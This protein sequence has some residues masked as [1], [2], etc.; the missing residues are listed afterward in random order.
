MEDHEETIPRIYFKE[1]VRE[2]LIKKAGIHLYDSDLDDILPETETTTTHTIDL[3]KIKGVSTKG[4]IFTFSLSNNVVTFSNFDG[5][6]HS[7]DKKA[8]QNVLAKYQENIPDNL[9]VYV[10]NNLIKKKSAKEIP[11]EVKIASALP[12]R[13]VKG[14]LVTSSPF[15]RGRSNSFQ[16]ISTPVR[17][18]RRASSLG[19]QR[20]R[21]NSI[22]DAYIYNIERLMKHPDEYSKHHQIFV[23][24][25]ILHALLDPAAL[26]FLRENKSQF[27]LSCRLTKWY[28]LIESK[29][30]H[31]AMLIHGELIKLAKKRDLA[32]F[33]LYASFFQE[34]EA[35]DLQKELK[36]VTKWSSISDKQ[37]TAAKTKHV[38][39]VSYILEQSK[40]DPN[41]IIDAFRSF[42]SKM[43]KQAVDFFCRLNNKQLT[44]F[45]QKNNKVLGD[46]V[47][48]LVRLIFSDNTYRPE[49]KELVVWLNIVF[50]YIECYAVL[51]DFLFASMPSYC[52]L[53][54]MSGDDITVLVN[55]INQ[56]KLQ[57]E[58]FSR[59]KKCFAEDKESMHCLSLLRNKKFS[60]L[61]QLLESHNK[62]ELF[63]SMLTLAN[64]KVDIVL[65]DREDFHVFLETEKSTT[66]G[67]LLFCQLLERLKLAF[68]FENLTTDA[69]DR[70]QSRSAP[71]LLFREKEIIRGIVKHPFICQKDVG[72]IFE[73]EQPIV[74]Q[75]H[76]SLWLTKHGENLRLL[77]SN[78]LPHLP[79]H[80]ED[81]AQL[82]RDYRQVAV[83]KLAS[84][85]DY[86]EVEKGKKSAKDVP[87]KRDREHY[88]LAKFPKVITE[89]LNKDKRLL[90]CIALDELE[91]LN[92]KLKSVAT[93]QLGKK[94]F[95]YTLMKHIVIRVLQ[96]APASKKKWTS[97]TLAR[98]LSTKLL[99]ALEEN[100]EGHTKLF[101]DSTYQN[102]CVH[103]QILFVNKSLGESLKKVINE[104]INAI[105]LDADNEIPEDALNESFFNELI[106]EF[107]MTLQGV[108]HKVDVTDIYSLK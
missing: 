61:Q 1:A 96:N 2:L 53:S 22:T 95:G 80:L 82:L 39:S 46:N 55:F 98:A 85:D 42:G 63:F 74:R 99:L 75:T 84:L 38:L 60:P 92:T 34:K 94:V 20:S 67:R 52:F 4:C 6:N 12:K 68:V 58:L 28:G 72:Y 19:F 69:S 79:E 73:R 47:M 87:G 78:F 91:E 11:T 83:G 41:F 90:Y 5:F 89:H 29:F 101:S 56:H 10:T 37:K 31:Q 7:D 40:Q 17:S 24:L 18:R 86:S 100:F 66:L 97:W 57:S 106:N 8:F 48:V 21:Q 59:V 43:R 33:I 13:F 35:K 27:L 64:S 103:Q 14:R 104:K 108:D 30:V 51:P 45:F 36:P 70:Q 71:T 102:V 3:T 77:L 23:R 25:L 32:P 49:D 44:V 9:Q 26:K 93:T 81:V 65:L 107:C 50:N 15:L 88:E 16:P 76:T 62:C 105:K 54:Q